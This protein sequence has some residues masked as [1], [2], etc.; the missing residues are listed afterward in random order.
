[1]MAR[2]FLRRMNLRAPALAFA[3][4]AALMPG[5]VPAQTPKFDYNP[6]EGGAPVLTYHGLVVGFDTLAKVRQTLGAPVH[7]AAWYNYKLLYSAGR[8]EGL[9]DAVH[10]Q[11]NQ[12]TATIGDIEAA[13]V[14]EGYETDAKIRAKLG[15]PEYEIRMATWRMID[16]TARGLRFTLAPDGHTIGV[17]YITPGMT[18][19]HEGARRFVDLSALR[20]GPQP[21][22]AAAADDGGLLCG[23][24]EVVISPQQG[25]WLN[26]PFTIHDDMKARTA[27]FRRGELTVA[28]VGADLFGAGWDDLKV[29]RDRAKAAGVTA[30]IIGMAHNHAVP[31]T[32]GVYGFYP[33]KYVKWLQDR[34]LEGITQAVANLKPVQEFRAASKELPMD[35]ARVIGL[36]RNARNPGIID[37]TVNVM[38]AIGED[39]KPIATLV[40]FACHVE[41]LALG[42]MK[43]GADFPGYMAEKMK[44]DG[45]GQPVFLNGA[46][47]GMV[48]GD[49]KAR[50][51]EASEEMGLQLAAIVKDLVAVARPPAKFVFEAATKRLEIPVTN[52]KL[53]M[54][55]ESTGL[56][57]FHD[58][59][60]VTDMQ[61]VR[62]GE[63]EIVAIPGELLPEVAYEVL[64]EMKGFPRVIV[65]LAN[66]EMGYIIPTD[67]FREKSYEE[68]MSQGPATAPIVRDTAIRM[69]KGIK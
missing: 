66:D 22:P 32:I 5:A 55:V 56:R 2:S 44:A 40:N 26:R 12:D 27:V 38:Q 21:A 62:L 20:Q 3:A 6:T 35:G 50:T 53:K 8:G 51:F 69:L 16:Y 15:E 41:G 31:D 42:V 28:F 67:D 9:T 18:R 13:S 57:K 4:V 48:S 64:E 17:V 60:M 63:A 47:G 37:P 36:F 65:G 68:S 43:I 54:L 24:S 30:T 7:E 46:L 29:V 19:V 58:G 34:L 23:T 25:D 45:M 59:R 10:V 33:E 49:N 11:G 52:P 14:P 39:G 61:L 1:M